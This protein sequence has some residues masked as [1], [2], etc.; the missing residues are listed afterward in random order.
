MRQLFIAV[1]LLTTSILVRS[2]GAQTAAPATL[3]F[4]AASVKRNTTADFVLG[5]PRFQGGNA[6]QNQ[7]LVEAIKELAAGEDCSPAQLCIAW[8]AH[9]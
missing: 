4:E 5:M 1:L 9:F 7:K 6:Q 2:L 3:R 8:K